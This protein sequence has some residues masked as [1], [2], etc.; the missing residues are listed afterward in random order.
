MGKIAPM[1]KTPAKTKAARREL[2]LASCE[3]TRQACNRLTD[4][5]RRQ[6]REQALAIIYGHDAK[7][8]ARSR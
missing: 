6:L 7:P 8:A 1:K 5:E 2:L 4:A 3:A